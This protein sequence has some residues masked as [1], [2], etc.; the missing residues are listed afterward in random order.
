MC[1]EGCGFTVF[2][3]VRVCVCVR[4]LINRLCE[5]TADLLARLNL[6]VC[7]CE[8]ERGLTHCLTNRL[9]ESMAEVLARLNLNHQTVTDVTMAML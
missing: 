1:F 9:C 2:I 6:C 4:G 5:S 8:R 7:V 3:S